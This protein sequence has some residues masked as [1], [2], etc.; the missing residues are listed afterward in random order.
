VFAA[1]ELAA[2]KLDHQMRRAADRRRVHHGVRTPQSVASATSTA[3]R[4]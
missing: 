4:T 1:L 3:L 2:D